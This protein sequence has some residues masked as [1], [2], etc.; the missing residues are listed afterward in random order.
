M[1]EKSIRIKGYL[2][3][4]FYLLYVLSFMTISILLAGCG[5]GGGGAVSSA[6]D[7]TAYS[8]LGISGT[9]SGTNISLTVPNGTSLTALIATFTTT[10][11]T[12][13]V[14]STVQTSWTTANNFTNSVT[15]TV[16]AE[17]SSTKSYIVTVTAASPP[18]AGKYVA[19]YTVTK[20]SVLRVIPNSYIN[21]ARTTLHIA[22]NHTS[23][24]T[25]VSYG[26]YGLPGFKSGDATKF[27]ITSNTAADP[28]K[29]DFKDNQIGGAYSDLS[30]ADSNWAT[31]RDQ[32]RTYL[33]N[34]ANANI[35]VMMWS[36]CDISGH[37]VSN[38]LSS[39]QTLINEYGVGGSKIG[40][41]TGKT[42]TTPVTFIF[43]T[44][45]ANG[46]ANTGAGNPKEQAKLIT[47]YCTAHG[48]FCIDYYSID[49]HAMNDTYY[50]DV[51]DDAYSTTYGGNFYQDWQTAH[52]LGTDWYQNRTS[53]GGSVSYGQHNSQHITANRKGFA[54][55]WVLAR[56]AGWDGVSP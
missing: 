55:W 36:W 16:T 33:D 25:H 23:H 45:H 54:F 38:Y 7:I 29:L 51:N 18:V 13:R 19:D 47:D 31:W 3:K 53:P 17:D 4:S 32:V 1:L 30:Q 27:G 41:G 52:T 9:I 39:M 42:R 10:G 24:G 44:G 21:T 15:Y 46:N 8:I 12:V 20:D 5:E 26:A 49:S 37:S 40:T 22:Y 2:K 34:A 56:I 48:Y 6:K 43:F 11:Q 28:N 50:E 35:N 14:G